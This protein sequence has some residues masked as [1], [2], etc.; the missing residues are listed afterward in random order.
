MNEY[1]ARSE[2]LKQA[3]SMILQESSKAGIET[4][5][6]GGMAV[7]LTSPCTHDEPYARRIEDLDFAVSSKQGYQFSRLLESA[8]FA[9]DH[10]FNSIHGETRMLFSSELTDIDVFVEEFGVNH[11][12]YGIG[13]I[14][15]NFR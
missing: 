13:G 7:Y 8:G 5:L 3:A 14:P 6:L 10:E 4:R 1:A 12:S 9:G 15:G 2:E 11:F